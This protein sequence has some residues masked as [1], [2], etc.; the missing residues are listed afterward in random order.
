MLFGCSEL[1]K[2]NARVQIAVGET[3]S[4]YGAGK[5][6]A[7]SLIFI[8]GCGHSGAGETDGGM[9]WRPQHPLAPT[10][11][12]A[13]YRAVDRGCHDLRGLHAQMYK[14]PA[15]SSPGLLNSGCGDRI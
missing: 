9:T 4:G 11:T 6:V 14:S 15:L 3:R 10:A 12:G 7:S 5:P 2:I 1:P 13:D 8:W